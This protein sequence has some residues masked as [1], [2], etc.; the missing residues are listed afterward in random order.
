VPDFR[1]YRAGFAPAL[2]SVIVLLFALTAPPGPLPAVVAPAEFDEVA[3]ARTA[4]QIVEAAPDRAPGSEGDAAIADM[5]ER[6]F[7]EVDEGE[8]AEQ[9]FEAEFEGEDVQLRNVILTLPGDSERTV[10]VLAPRDSVSEPG[11][12]SSAAATAT[13]LQLADEMRTQSHSKSLVFVSTDGSS[14]GATG[15]R[16][17]ARSYTGGEEIDAVIDLW[18]PGFATPRQPYVLE[19]STGP[20]SPSAQLV[21]TA[22]AALADQS[23]RTQAGEGAL[24]ELAALALPAGLSDQA[25][26]VENG[27]RAIGLSSAGQ[28]PLSSGEDQLEDL[29]ASTLDEFGR[30][31]LVLLTTVDG[32]A[33]P[34]AHGPATYVP[35]AGNLVPGWT[36]A[37]LALALLLPAALASADGIRRSLRAHEGTG[38][39]IGWA[40]S[41]SMPLIAALVLFYFLGLVGLVARP[42]FPFDPNQFGVGAGQVI[43]MVLL[44]GVVAGGYYAIRAWRVPGA[45]SRQAAVPALG[46]LSTLAV[47][48]AWLANPFLGLLLVPTAHVWLTC[49]PRRGPLPWP[50][51]AVA[52]VVS[53]V[54]IATAI[55]HLC[56]SLALGSS[57]PWLLLLMVSDG[58]FG[59]GTMLALCLILGGFVGAIALSLRGWTA[60]R[61]PRPPSSGA[62]P[63]PIRTRKDRRT[64]SRPRADWTHLRSRPRPEMTI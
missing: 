42:P 34:L 33:E 52:A 54:P 16:E 7:A 49:A 63:E 19:S 15:A 43:V 11:A 32:A 47:F 38:W 30:T 45:L 10:A 55:D 12:V 59:F 57:A 35:L 18:Q 31:A 20:Q 9:Q 28:R 46:I 56:S 39:A 25:V 51:V 58:Q 60:T 5:V 24:D 44:A 53:L 29:S 2:T 6:R 37:L 22:E 62:G 23:G 17:F 40:L 21:R 61:R 13:L 41:R 1:I 4:R 8:V 14:A 36:L 3:A 48:G 26:L 64:A 27:L 50:L